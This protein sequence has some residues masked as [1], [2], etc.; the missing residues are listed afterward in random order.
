M[1]EGKYEEAAK[2]FGEVA[3]EATARGAIHRAAQLH[4]QAAKAHLESGDEGQAIGHGEQAVGALTRSGDLPR[5]ARV[6]NRVT[7]ELEERGYA[8]AAQQLRE[9]FDEKLR[10]HGLSLA[11]AGATLPAAPK[12]GDLPG[13]CPACLGP[14]RSDEVDWADATSA[15]CPFC[16]TIVKTT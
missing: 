3:G 11:E 14:L 2:L 13:Q 9:R 4:L 10:E 8:D 6:L 7:A 12:R 1:A 5:A 16:G 15:E